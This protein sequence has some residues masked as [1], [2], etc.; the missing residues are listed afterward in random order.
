MYSLLTPAVVHLGSD[1]RQG[2]WISLT[3]LTITAILV[4]TAFAQV[5]AHE[6]ATV[7]LASNLQVASYELHRGEKVDYT[8]TASSFLL[9]TIMA[10]LE[11]PGHNQN[12]DIVYIMLNTS[13]EG[14]FEAPYDPPDVGAWIYNFSFTNVGFQEINVAY[15]ISKVRSSGPMIFMIALSI[16]VVLGA[17]FAAILLRSARR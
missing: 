1:R 15:D 7:Q 13:D 4:L 10:H 5:R 2:V 3:V 9:F 12:D 17:V 11:M 14:T 16:V 8:W 6:T